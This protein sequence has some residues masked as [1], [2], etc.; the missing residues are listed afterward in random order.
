MKFVKVKQFF[1]DNRDIYENDSYFPNKV[2]NFDSVPLA[3]S[4]NL[5]II[6][7][8]YVIFPNHNFFDTCEGFERCCCF[9]KNGHQDSKKNCLLFLF[10]VTK[11][12]FYL[13]DIINDPKIFPVCDNIISNWEIY[14]I[15]D[16]KFKKTNQDSKSNLEWRGSTLELKRVEKYNYMD[17]FSDDYE[18]LCGKDN[19][20]N[21]LYFPWNQKCPINDIFIS[22]YRNDLPDYKWLRLD[23]NH[24][25]YYTNAKTD[26]KI[27]VDLRISS[28]SEIALNPGGDSESNYY[29]IP[30]YE[31]IDRE[32]NYNLYAINYLGA[33][34]S[35]VSS[36]KLKYFDDNCESHITLYYFK[37][38]LFSI[39]YALLL[40]K[41]L[42]IC[43][44]CDCCR[45]C[46]CACCDCD[47]PCGCCDCLTFLL[48][49]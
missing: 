39:E 48:V 42:L 10:F 27:L 29:S 4:L 35:S 33:N 26:G 13:M 20:G 16:I 32:Y 11:F 31:E 9:E 2:L 19:L 44:K 14:P 46:Y 47:C 37:I 24:Y 22:K 3:V 49:L 25:L 6:N 18:K 30:F 41:I 5:F 43:L 36:K 7:L 34:F 17:I 38:V 8:L 12:V 23:Y 40:W 15:V 1:F 28:D 21:N 45:C